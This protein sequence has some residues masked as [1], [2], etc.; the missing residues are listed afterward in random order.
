VPANS[1]FF[2]YL[3]VKTDNI[4]QAYKQQQRKPC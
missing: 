3:C 2:S 1:G 4:K